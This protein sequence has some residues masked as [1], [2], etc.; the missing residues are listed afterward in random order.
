MRDDSGIENEHEDSNEPSTRRPLH[1]IFRCSIAALRSISKLGERC[2][3]S[4]NAAVVGFRDVL[5]NTLQL[6]QSVFTPLSGSCRIIELNIGGMEQPPP[7]ELIIALVSVDQQDKGFN[8]VLDATKIAFGFEL[9]AFTE[10]GN[11]MD[12][13][14]RC[15]AISCRGANPEDAKR[16]DDIIGGEL[17]LPAEFGVIWIIVWWR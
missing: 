4:L 17:C 3:D 6:L 16:L 9:M 12:P 2:K 14:L 15:Q 8:Q 10:K 7:S 11:K 5:R 1:G 13:A